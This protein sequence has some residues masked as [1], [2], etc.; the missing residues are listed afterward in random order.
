MNNK[1]DPEKAVETIKQF[2]TNRMVQ[3]SLNGYVIGLSGGID[4][5]LSALL[6]VE[7]IGKDNLFGVLMPYRTSSESSVTDAMELVN[8]LGI[9]HKMADISPMIDVYY[10]KID[11]SN[12]LRAG[13]KMARERM[14]ILFDFA[15]EMNR[16]VLGTG[17]RTEI[18]LGYTTWYGDAACS[19]DPL[20]QLYKTEVRQVAKL[21]GVP[22]SIINKPP[23]AD[24]WAGQTDEDEIGVNYSKIDNLLK[25]MIDHNIT[26]INKLIEAGTDKTEITRV[27][28]LINKNA[29]KRNIPA[30]A[31]LGRVDIPDRIRLEEN[32]Q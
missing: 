32:S 31:S 5:A 20:G 17:N 29:F 14:A 7:A 6:A 1:F 22:D 3:S 13:N 9:K 4:S 2:I 28:E 15:F 12:R 26:S 21:V 18:A 24:L 27:I 8:K 23:S 25:M 16:M 30:I 19:I 11:D 10:E